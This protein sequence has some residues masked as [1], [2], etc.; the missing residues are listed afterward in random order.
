MCTE[1]EINS[2]FL[3]LLKKFNLY[4]KTLQQSNLQTHVVS[5]VN[6]YQQINIYLYV[7]FCF[8]TPYLVCCWSINTDFTVNST[9]AH[10]W[11]K[12]YLT[13][14]FFSLLRNT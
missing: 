8:K 1:E 3:D 2:I 14:V 10:A 9:I 7:C 13:R 4:L 11:N 5:L 12:N 6:I